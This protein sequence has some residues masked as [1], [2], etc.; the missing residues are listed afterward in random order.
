[1]RSIAEWAASDRMLTDPVA[2]PATSFPTVS[3]VL[4]ATESQATRLFSIEK[5]M[6]PNLRKLFRRV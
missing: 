3:T 4:L 2:N 6:L 1:M 5:L